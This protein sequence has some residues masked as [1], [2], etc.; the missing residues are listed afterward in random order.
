MLVLELPGVNLQQFQSSLQLRLLSFF[1]LTLAS[2]KFVTK[3]LCSSS[4]YDQKL[5]SSLGVTF[6]IN[7][8]WS[9]KFSA[10][11]RHWIWSVNQNAMTFLAKH[12]WL[13]YSHPLWWVSDKPYLWNFNAELYISSPNAI[14]LSWNLRFRWYLLFQITHSSATKLMDKLLHKFW[15]LLQNVPQSN[16]CGWHWNLSYSC[17]P[18]IIM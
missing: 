12:M 17:M 15:E 8:C 7:V 6:F 18:L 2:K 10:H 16:M 11:F 5:S 4:W 13:N 9:G 1:F 14:S 3:N